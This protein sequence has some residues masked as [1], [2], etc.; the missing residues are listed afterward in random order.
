MSY[1]TI[2]AIP[3]LL[4]VGSQPLAGAAMLAA[5]VGLLVGVRRAHRLVRCVHECRALTFDLGGEVRITVA[6][7]P[8]DDPS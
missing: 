1:A 3:I 5:V 2:A 7:H 6:Q 4:W 8:T